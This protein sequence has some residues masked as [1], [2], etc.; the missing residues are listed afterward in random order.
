MADPRLS[1]RIALI[2]GSLASA[3]ACGQADAQSAAPPSHGDAVHSAP[4]STTTSGMTPPKGWKPLPAI[5]AAIQLVV[6]APGVTIEGIESWGEPA[7]GCYGVWI[8]LHGTGGSPEALAEQVLESLAAEK[9]E[10]RDVVKPAEDGVLSLGL[11]RAPY[12]GRLR[13]RLEDGRL[14]ALACVNN[15]REPAACEASCTGLLGGLP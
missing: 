2:A 5:A 15:Q 14:T 3:T 13:A 11:E 10:V 4:A 7:M 6:P 8:A 12:R 1:V 9:I